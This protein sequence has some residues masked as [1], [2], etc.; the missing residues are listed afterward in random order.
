MELGITDSLDSVH[1]PYPD[2]NTAFE[3]LDLF[4]ILSLD[5]KDAPWLPYTEQILQS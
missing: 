1:C 4:R 2:F 3:K 5:C